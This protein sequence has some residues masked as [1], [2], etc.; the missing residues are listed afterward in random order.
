MKERHDSSTSIPLTVFVAQFGLLEQEST[1][2][3]KEDIQMLVRL[4]L[5]CLE[6]KDE[7]LSAR[8]KSIIKYCAGRKM[9]QELG[10]E[11]GNTAPMERRLKELVGDHHWK[12][13]YD[14]LDYYIAQEKR[15][16]ASLTP[17]VSGRSI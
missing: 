1:K 7:L 15:R 2:E 16:D 8:A 13:V 6:R 5:K 4:L 10:Y 14:Y 11:F 3:A 17:P 12:R 9:R